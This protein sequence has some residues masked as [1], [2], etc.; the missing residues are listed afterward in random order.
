MRTQKGEL[1]R[2]LPDLD[3]H[4]E[5]LERVELVDGESV[6]D[7]RLADGDFS[8][9]TIGQLVVHRSLI[10]AV[11]FANATIQSVR[12][13]DVRFVRCD[14]SNSVM[15]GLQ[16]NRVEFI[17]CRLMGMK[18]AE[19][20]MEDVLLERCDSRYAQ[21]TA[22]AMR[23]SDFIDT[24]LQESDFRGVNLENSRWV[25]SS[26]SRADLNG[27]KMTGADLRGAEIDGLTVGATD[28]AGAIVSPSQAMELAR[29]LG[30]VIR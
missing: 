16:A 7:G 23:R 10:E 6:E 1:R 20:R 28:V 5:Q 29:L 14:L 18:A 21:F 12:L 24:Q 3:D 2:T 19:C 11:S 15:R 4:P 8:G 13:R 30:L 27:A 22:G 26:L 17:D 9:R 25:R